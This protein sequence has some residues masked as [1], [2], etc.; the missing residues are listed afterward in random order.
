MFTKSNTANFPVPF[1]LQSRHSTG[2]LSLRVLG[3][4]TTMWGSFWTTRITFKRR[5]SALDSDLSARGSSKS[6]T[7]SPCE[8][9]SPAAEQSRSWWLSSTC[10]SSSVPGIWPVSAACWKWVKSISSRWRIP[11]QILRCPTESMDHSEV[12]FKMSACQGRNR[13]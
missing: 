6:F 13:S 1:L 11:W 5:K 9:T 4:R 8:L 7:G 3:G 12:S 2:K 10:I